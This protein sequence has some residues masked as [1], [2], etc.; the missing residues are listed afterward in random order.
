[1]PLSVLASDD[2]AKQL[3]FNL[4]LPRLIT[5]ALLGMSLSAAGGVMQMLFRNPLVEPGFLGSQPG[6]RIWRGTEHSLIQ[7]FNTSYR[8]KCHPFCSI[9]VSS[10]L[11][12]CSP[13]TR[14]WLGLE[15]SAFRHRGFSTILIRFGYSQICRRPHLKIAGNRFLVNGRSLCRLLDRFTV[16]PACC[17]YWF[18]HHFPH[19]LAFE[20]AFAQ[21]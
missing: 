12:H 21:R 10:F 11:F 1:M 4:R 8:S 9:R 13:Y 18:S 5:A 14:R 17:H 16:Y 6:S 19:A 15:I 7:H 3:V 20:S 2:L